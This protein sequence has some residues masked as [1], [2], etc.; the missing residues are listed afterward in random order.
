MNTLRFK[1]NI[2]CTGCLETV[3]PHLNEVDTISSWEVDLLSPNK[4]LTVT[5]ED[6]AED[7]IVNA[8]KNAGFELVK[9]D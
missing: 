2:K 5:S 6:S 8:V 9:M 4:T 1:S 3:T 7:K